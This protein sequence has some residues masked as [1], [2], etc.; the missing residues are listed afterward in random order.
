MPKIPKYIPLSK[1]DDCCSSHDICYATCNADKDD[2]DW[3]F[4]RCLYSICSDIE[5]FVSEDLL[6]GKFVEMCIDI[7]YCKLISLMLTPVSIF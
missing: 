4:R 7:Q 1:L 5:N 3:K 2:C 6:K